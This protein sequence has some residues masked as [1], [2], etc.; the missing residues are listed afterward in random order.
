MKDCT[1]CKNAHTDERLTNDTDLSY[2]SIGDPDYEDGYRAYLRTGD[3][4]PTALLVEKKNDLIWAYYPYFCP[5]CG[6]VLKENEK[7]RGK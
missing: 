2:M 5:N 1:Y 3:N 7:W 6:R 4:R